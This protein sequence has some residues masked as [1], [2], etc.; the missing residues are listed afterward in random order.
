MC[1]SY[2]LDNL[3]GLYSYIHNSIKWKRH[4]GKT[5][6]I[7]HSGYNV[8][9]LKGYSGWNCN[10]RLGEFRKTYIL[11]IATQMEPGTNVKAR[12][13]E[14]NVTQPWNVG[15]DPVTLNHQTWRIIYLYEMEFVYP[16]CI[17]REFCVFYQKGL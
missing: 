6:K 2:N 8:P 4:D 12:T 13:C 11:P 7:D 14:K 17:L 10:S 9:N 15:P 16:R 5:K 1:Q 3:G